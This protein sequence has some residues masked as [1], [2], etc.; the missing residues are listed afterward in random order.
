MGKSLTLLIGFEG[1]RKEVVVSNVVE[2]VHTKTLK[3]VGYG[4]GV[5]I[6]FVM[7]K[8]SVG[9]NGRVRSKQEA[10]VEESHASLVL[11]LAVGAAGLMEE[12]L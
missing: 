7:G 4:L 2:V 11:T 8:G 5:K 10:I 6:E 3:Q 1:Q 9:E 12:S